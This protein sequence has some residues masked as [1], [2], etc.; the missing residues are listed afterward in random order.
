MADGIDRMIVRPRKMQLARALTP[1]LAPCDGQRIKAAIEV[2]NRRSINYLCNRY[3]VNP[4]DV[5]NYALSYFGPIVEE[6][7]KDNSIFN[8]KNP[9]QATTLQVS[10]DA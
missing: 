9:K 3:K 10:V 6:L 2:A 8:K 5:I 7:K 4:S 1:E